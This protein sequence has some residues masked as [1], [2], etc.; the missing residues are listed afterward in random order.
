MPHSVSG[1]SRG[2]SPSLWLSFTAIAPSAP[3]DFQRCACSGKRRIAP[4]I[5]RP[6]YLTALG[7]D[8]SAIADLKG[9]SLGCARDI[10]LCVEDSTSIVEA[11]HDS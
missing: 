8:D 10:K 11:C 2:Y 7:L 9:Y 5:E 1:I 4:S 3:S 6:F